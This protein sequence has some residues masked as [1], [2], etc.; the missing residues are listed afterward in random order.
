MSSK[1]NNNEAREKIGALGLDVES[2]IKINSEKT[3]SK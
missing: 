2:C 3:T 1:Q